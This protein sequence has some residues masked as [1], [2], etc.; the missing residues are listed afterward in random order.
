MTEL[1]SAE[2]KGP[3][4]VPDGLPENG[5]CV[6]G[7]YLWVRRYRENGDGPLRGLVIYVGRDK[8]IPNRMFDHLVQLLG[9]G[10][11]MW[12]ESGRDY[13]EPGPYSTF[14][15]YRQ[16]FEG[17]MRW[18]V[19]EFKRSEYFY[20]PCNP[21]MESTV[22]Q[23]AKKK[24]EETTGDDPPIWMVIQSGND[25]SSNRRPGA[26]NSD[27]VDAGELEGPKLLRWLGLAP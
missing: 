21:E 6:S 26:G 4:L 18:T 9:G 15:R 11:S 27:A 22:R 16:C 14:A 17:L 19:D 23:A 25:W 5:K 13:F 1:P 7:V 3:I 12:D 10:Q 24:I 20:L 2:W 8:A